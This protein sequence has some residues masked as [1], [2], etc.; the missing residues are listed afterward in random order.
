PKTSAEPQHSWRC[1]TWLCPSK[2]GY[3]PPN[4]RSLRDS[5][6]F[7]SAEHIRRPATPLSKRCQ[8]EP[9]E[10]LLSF[11]K[12]T[13][14]RRPLA[15]TSGG[16]HPPARN[17]PGEEMSARAHRSPAILRQAHDDKAPS[18]DNV[19]RNTSAGPQHPCRRD[20]SVTPPKPCYP[21]TSSR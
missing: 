13:M 9:V 10:A 19:R 16:T 17:T 20:V 11:D 21:S 5:T 4:S 2:T 7:R 1:E 14:T 12:L 3:P 18:G 15:I 6:R 8:A